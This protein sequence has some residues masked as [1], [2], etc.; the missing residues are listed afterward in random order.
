M[1]K[2]NETKAEKFVRVANGRTKKAIKQ[3]RLIKQ[4]VGSKNYD[5]DGEQVNKLV[6]VLYDEVTAIAN[7]YKA[8]TQSKEP[9][10]DVF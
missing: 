9:I 3:L 10:E 1:T 8:R 2:E 6:N 4:V 5:V 7:A